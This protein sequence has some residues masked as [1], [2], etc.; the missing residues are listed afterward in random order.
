MF[1]QKWI[2]TR[3]LWHKESIFY[4]SQHVITPWVCDA[5]YSETIGW[6][7]AALHAE[8]YINTYK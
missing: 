5:V 4:P 3:P 8:K 6:P 2:L 1:G 7:Q